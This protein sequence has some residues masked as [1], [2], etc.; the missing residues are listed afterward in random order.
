[1]KNM[2]EIKYFDVLAGSDISDVAKEAIELAK[3]LNCRIIFDFNGK[4]LKVYHFSH[5]KEIIEE[6]YE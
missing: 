1:M 6:Y 4:K 5:L 3:K 2:T